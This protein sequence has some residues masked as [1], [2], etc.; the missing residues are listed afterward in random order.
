MINWHRLFGAVLYDFF[1]DSPYQVEL[2]KDLALKQQFLDVVIIHKKPHSSLTLPPLQLPD[3]FD[4]LAEHNLIT[5][6]SHQEAL[7]KYALFELYGHFIN[8]TKQVSTPKHPVHFDNCQLYA[9][10]A[11][12]PEKRLAEGQFKPLHTNAC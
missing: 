3:G 1:T 11:R 10:C 7:N 6:K 9:V 2:E 12:L 8:Y 5:F 4:N